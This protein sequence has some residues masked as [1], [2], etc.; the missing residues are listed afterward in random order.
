MTDHRAFAPGQTKSLSVTTTS[1]SVALGMSQ[2]PV[3]L[4]VRIY[5]AGGSTAF[6]RF[7]SSAGTVTA[8]TTDM[9]V[10]AGAIEVFTVFNTD[11]YTIT[12]AAITSAG[13]ATLYFTA[14]TGM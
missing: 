1:A 4:Q 13:T 9:P 2:G 8:V 14:G 11:G 12:A 5:N 7:G 3:R 10:P 6:V